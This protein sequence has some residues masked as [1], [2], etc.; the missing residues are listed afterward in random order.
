[1][2]LAPRPRTLLRGSVT[3]ASAALLLALTACAG[4]ASGNASGPSSSPVAGSGSAGACG[5]LGTGTAADPDGALKGL[6]SEAL[7]SFANYPYPVAAS[8]WQDLAAKKGP[9]KIGY[10]SIALMN[11]YNNNA[12]NTT[13]AHV[14]EY[15]KDGVVDSTLLKGIPADAA[16]QTPAEQIKLYNQL[17][18]QGVDG[19]ILGPL[20]GDAMADA[21]TAAGK[22]GIPTVALNTYIPSEY[23]IS[24]VINPY[25]QGMDPAANTLKQLG[26]KGNVLIV[27]GIPGETNDAVVYPGF[28]KMLE[29]CP[30]MKVAGEVVG[31]YSNATAKAEVMK[32]LASHPGQIDMVF[33]GGVMGPGIISA[34]EQSGRP[35]PAISF[36]GLQAGDSAWWNSK[37][38]SYTAFGTVGSGKQTADL[39]WRVM[40]RT[41][42]GQGP[43]VNSVV[44]PA[45][46][47][48]NE[49][50][51]E[52]APA[53]GD[54]NSPGEVGE[55]SDTLISE[56][57][58]DQFFAKP[59]EGTK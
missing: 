56:S 30:D 11:D 57:S 31:G 28:T 47:I 34:F 2:T 55:T 22:K 20:S 26:G 5:T 59:S 16:S 38:D 3:A 52:L 39:A 21:V 33:S 4:G 46:L 49:T 40:I 8:K 24:T 58:M 45:Q 42:T 25:L 35:V 54:L 7:K 1:M 51:G 17:V 14:V 44:T 29:G 6:N 12:L 10:V 13:E 48:T 15:S 9:L 32:F 53:G 50:V 41:L 43:K 36:S 27:R 19:I 37:K 18:D 23:A